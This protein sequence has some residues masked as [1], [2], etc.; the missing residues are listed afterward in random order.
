MNGRALGWVDPARLGRP[1]VGRATASAA[2]LRTLPP[3]VVLDRL[4]PVYDQRRVGSCTAQALAGAVEILQARAGMPQRR[5]DRVALYHRERQMIG[6]VGED[7]GAILADGVAVLRAGYEPELAE[8]PA[9]G[10]AWTQPP[11]R[12]PGD[13]PRLIFAEALA[14]DVP[15]I[16]WEIA[17]GHPVAVG[18]QVTPQWDAPEG[19]AVA[20]PA[21]SSRGGHAVLL[22][23]Y[24][25][26]AGAWLVRNSWGEGWGEG[27]Y[28][29][30]DWAWTEPP[31]CGEAIALRAVR[32][33]S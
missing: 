3:H 20:A 7:S 2:Q 8:P 26:P 18:V 30:L 10:P 23:G 31:W 22:V 6:S 4:P 13:A 28:A 14:L 33:P 32:G 25:V 27:G 16:A 21:G 5:P 17:N 29:R 9:W 15:S 11:P 1:H 24:D 19:G 12:R